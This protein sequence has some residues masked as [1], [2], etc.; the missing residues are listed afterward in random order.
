MYR[1]EGSI[2]LL[3]RFLGPTPV[4]GALFPLEV[5]AG[6]HVHP[7]FRCCAEVFGVPLSGIHRYRCL[8]RHTSARNLTEAP[9]GWIGGRMWVIRLSS[10]LEANRSKLAMLELE[11]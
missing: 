8:F 5:K 7:K 1:L 10:W 6:L 2:M 11:V 3:D 4:H 9:A